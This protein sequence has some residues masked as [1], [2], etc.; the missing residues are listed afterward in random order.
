VPYDR[1]EKRQVRRSIRQLQHV[2][3]WQLSILLVL[4]IF[5]AA[6]FLRLNNIGMVERRQAV[7]QADKDSTSDVIQARLYDLQRYVTAHMNADMGTIY[8]ENQ[9]KRDSQTSIDAASG[10]SNPNGNVFKKAQEVCAPKF[11]NLGHYSLAYQQCVIDQLNSYPSGSQLTST[12]QLPKADAYRHSFVSPLWSADF[13]GFSVLACLL[14]VLTII[15]RFV[16]LLILRAI[17][18]MRNRGV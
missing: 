16:G 2:K 15:G 9:Y 4:C 12:L 10:G 13:A 7:I 3:T 6:T 8:L 17:L 11:A 14:I 1:A 5:I 18:K